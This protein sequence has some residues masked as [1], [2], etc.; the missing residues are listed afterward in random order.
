MGTSPYYVDRYSSILG[1]SRNPFTRNPL[2]EESD[3]IRIFSKQESDSLLEPLV[4]E[5][6]S[7]VGSSFLVIT[8]STGSG[9][10]MRLRVIS[11]IFRENGASS[12]YYPTEPMIGQQIVEEIIL[13]AYRNYRGVDK[14][15]KKT[16]FGTS[17]QLTKEEMNEIISSASNAGKVVVKSLKST[18]PSCI[19]LD[20]IHNVFFTDESWIFFIFEM[21]REV[22]SN[23][24]EGSI[25]AMTSGREAF[26][27]IERRFPALSSR[28]HDIIRVEPLRDHEAISLVSKRIDLVKSRNFQS[29]LG[30]IDQEVVIEANKIAS[31]NPAKLLSILERAVDLAVVLG[32]STV[33]MR[34]LESIMETEGPLLEFL[35]S[36]PADIRDTMEVIIRKFNGGPVSVGDVAIEIE[37][38]VSKT[39]SRLEAMTAKNLLKRDSSGN[40]LVPEDIIG[41]MKEVKES[42]IKEKKEKTEKKIDELRK[43]SLDRIMRR[44][45][46]K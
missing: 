20:D 44:L 29:P 15:L 36:L 10:T 23:M 13:M 34:I 17:D 18:R 28:I 1:L 32:K 35:S 6:L 3:P 26:D 31:G 21:I 42:L 7:N 22:V 11:Q 46:A 43:K 45:K 24:P 40:Y 5:A 4:D 38:P 14:V 12:M 39:F 19:L 25:L 27:E 8:G 37:L 41:R 30:P 33:D 9:R 2:L 16:I